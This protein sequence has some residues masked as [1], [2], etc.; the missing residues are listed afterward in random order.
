MDRLS[1]FHVVEVEVSGA[2]GFSVRTVRRNPAQLGAVTGIALAGHPVPV[3]IPVAIA[4][5]LG[6]GGSEGLAD[7]HAVLLRLQRSSSSSL[8]CGEEWR[9]SDG[10]GGTDAGRGYRNPDDWRG[11]EAEGVEGEREE[12]EGER[13]RRR[14]R[15]EKEG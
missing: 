11:E 9:E 13:E 15:N 12:E 4:T 2:R 1:D 7:V 14:K 6:P 5:R 3:P 8:W 10:E